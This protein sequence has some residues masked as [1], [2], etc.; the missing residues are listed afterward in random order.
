[1]EDENLLNLEI[2]IPVQRLRDPIRRVLAGG[3]AAEIELEGRDRRGKPVRVRV[4]VAPL[5]SLPGADGT[6]GAILLDSAERS[7]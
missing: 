4:E 1:V 7:G 3:S 6:L 5:E 2:G